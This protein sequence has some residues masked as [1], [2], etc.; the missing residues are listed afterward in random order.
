V[1]A[2]AGVS[3]AGARVAGR[4]FCVGAAAGE[5]AAARMDRSKSV[6]INRRFIFFSSICLKTNIFPLLILLGHIIMVHSGIT[7]LA[8]PS[9]RVIFK[10]KPDRFQT[11]LSGLD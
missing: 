2:G 8:V 3:F 6:G 5:Q 7:T 10:T 11:S 4:L 1:S 9:N